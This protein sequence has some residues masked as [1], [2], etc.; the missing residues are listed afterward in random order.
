VKKSGF[1]LIECMVYCLIMATIMMLW[2]NGVASFTRICT[3]QMYQTNSLSTVYSALDVFT[4][5]IRKAPHATYVWPVITDIA[6]V[7]TLPDA[8]SIGWEYKNNRLLR[9]HGQ[10]N[11]ATKQWIKKT[12]SLILTDVQT[13]SFLFNR[14]NQ[15]DMS[16]QILLT[17]H[18]KTFSRTSYVA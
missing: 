7:F 16:V 4:R 14:L 15:E 3:A 18:G 1:S 8:S 11:S 17:L 13:C 9:Y 2:F 12:K 6:F 5:D 10:Y